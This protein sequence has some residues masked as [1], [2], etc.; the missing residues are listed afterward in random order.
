[1]L[2]LMKLEMKKF[3]FGGYFRGVV[4]ANIAIIGLLLLIYFD[5]TQDNSLAFSDYSEAFFII[6]MIVKGTFMIFAAV[7]IGKLII[8][9]FKNKT[10]SVLFTYPIERKKI[11]TAKLTIIGV[12]TFAVILVSTLFSVTVLY[13]VDAKMQYIPDSLTSGM[14]IEQ[15]LGLL[16][17]AL[18]GAGMS[19]IPLY[20]GMR[21]KSVSATIVSSLI[22]VMLVC[23][24][25][26]GFSLS[27]IIAIPLSLAA[28][29]IIIA[30]LAIRDI[31]HVDLV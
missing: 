31:E 16:M 15:A 20:F 27:S 26:M 17:H 24:N 4:I 7:L 11:M 19:L 10:I 3:R 8:N 1:M 18:S 25:N 9:E 14:L 6:S 21:K 2:N 12:L 23:S 30:Y 5:E 22:V 28:I 13:I 29:G